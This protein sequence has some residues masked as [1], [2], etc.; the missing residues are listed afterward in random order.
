M[1]KA[2]E[3]FII[4]KRNVCRGAAIPVVF[5]T[6]TLFGQILIEH[7]YRQKYSGDQ[8]G[9]IRIHRGCVGIRIISSG[10][11]VEGVMIMD[12]P[13]PRSRLSKDKVSSENYCF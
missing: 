5:Q 13:G 6:N 1:N 7:V 11:P 10:V 2:K 4:S 9:R 8:N 3:S 12:G